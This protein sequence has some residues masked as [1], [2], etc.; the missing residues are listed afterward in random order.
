[1]GNCR[2]NGRMPLAFGSSPNQ[3][4]ESRD[5][6]RLWWIVH[7]D[8]ISEFRARRAWP[9]MLLLGIVVALVFSIQMDLLPH[10]RQRLVG[11]L[12]WL[13][14]FFAGMT[15]IDRSFASERE[16]GCWDGLK[17]FP[18]SPAT[19]YWAKLL[20]NAV[21]LAVLQCLLIPLFFVVSDFPVWARPG[22]LLL[23]GLL[24][25]LG[26]A[27]VGTVVSALATSIGR[28]GHLLVLLVLPLVIPVVLAAAEA[29]RLL[30]ENRIDATWWQWIQ[31]LGAFAIVFVTA[32]TLLFEYAMEE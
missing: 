30:V 18:L 29:T 25:N 12:L 9:T 8:L 21:A 13:A 22:E 24:G 14:I 31:L 5:M 11:G 27:A 6:S 3:E 15:A 17:L 28:S 32:G 23:I 2:A 10:Q 4:S 20:V 16:D 1:M 19:L 26:I 7:K